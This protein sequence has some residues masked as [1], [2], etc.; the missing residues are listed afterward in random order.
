MTYRCP[1]PLC[2]ME[3]NIR[4]FIYGACHA[5]F[6][7]YQSVNDLIKLLAG[8]AITGDWLSPIHI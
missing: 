7:N 5:G 2:T 8:M 3:K 1:I 6:S 4:R